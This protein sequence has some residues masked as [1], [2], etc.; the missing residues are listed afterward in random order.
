MKGTK[1]QHTLAKAYRSVLHPSPSVK[2]GNN[3]VLPD[4]SLPAFEFYWPRSGLLTALGITYTLQDMFVFPFDVENMIAL[5]VSME[6]VRSRPKP[7][8]CFEQKQSGRSP[9][10]TGYRFHHANEASIVTPQRTLS[11]ANKCNSIQC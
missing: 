11:A 5:T 7:R 10:L 8:Q 3:V 6:E 1:T 4:V 2:I 9:G